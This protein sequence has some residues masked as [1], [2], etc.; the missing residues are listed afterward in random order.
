MWTS[1]NYSVILSDFLCKM[2]TD[3]VNKKTATLQCIIEIT[4]FPLL[5]LYKGHFFQ[6]L[7]QEITDFSCVLQEMGMKPHFNNKLNRIITDKD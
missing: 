3:L 1:S 6:L 4:A 2:S 7:R 5:I